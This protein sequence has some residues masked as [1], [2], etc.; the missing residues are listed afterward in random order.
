MEVLSTNKSLQFAITKKLSELF[1]NAYKTYSG[2]TDIDQDQY[3]FISI[4]DYN[5]D[6]YLQFDSDGSLITD[7]KDN[8]I[9]FFP[10]TVGEIDGDREANPDVFISDIVIPISMLI[11]LNSVEDTLETINVFNNEI[12][13]K[14]YTIEYY[15]FGKTENYKLTLLPNMP[16]LDNISS[17]G[18]YYKNISFELVGVLS[19]GVAYGN[20]IKYSLSVDNENWYSFTKVEPTTTRNKDLH[21]D[22]VINE[23][24]TKATEKTSSWVKEMSIIAKTNDFL[25]KILLLNIDCIRNDEFFLKIEYTGFNMAEVNDENYNSETDTLTIIKKIYFQELSYSDDIGDFISFEFT[26]VERM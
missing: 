25:T 19:C 20:Q 26:M 3:K 16:S 4:F 22:Q 1:N 2:I 24:N 6:Q 12:I 17:Q 11:E 13:G 5:Y 23:E 7:K 14:V 10:V 9:R 15:D 21:I 8:P 18:E